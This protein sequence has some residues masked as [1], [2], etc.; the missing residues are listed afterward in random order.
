[1]GLENAEKISELNRLWP[2]GTDPRSQGDDHL[3]MLKACLLDD[4][5]TATRTVRVLTSSGNWTKPAGLKFLIIEG[6]GPGGGCS[7][8]QATAA[9]TSSAS[10]GGGGGGYGWS[11]IAAASLPATVAYVIG[12][13]GAAAGGGGLPGGAGGTSS[14]AGASFLGGGGS[15]TPVVGTTRAIALGGASG[16]ATG[17]TLQMTGGPGSEGTIF[18]MATVPMFP[19]AGAGG[20]SQFAPMGPVRFGTKGAVAGRNYGGGATGGC[21]FINQAGFQSGAAGGASIIKLVEI[22]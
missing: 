3:R 4:V 11:L 7:V 19:I 14:F 17:S 18:S 12:Q 13:P 20:G 22:F 8:A 16:G 1:M 9:D 10:A 6:V 5:M 15:A 21:N 2:L